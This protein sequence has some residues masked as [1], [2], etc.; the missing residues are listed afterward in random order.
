VLRWSAWTGLTVMALVLLLALS[1]VID[2]IFGSGRLAALV[3]VSIPQA[4]GPA[5]GAFVARPGGDRGSVGRGGQRRPAVI[6]LHEFWGLTPEI[7]SK[8]TL[9]SESEGYVVVAPDTLRGTTTRWFPRALYQAITTPVERVN[10]DL[11]VVFAWLAAQPDVDPARIAVVGFC[12]GGG[13]AFA[14]SLHSTRLAATA[15]FYG[16][17]ET[18]PARLRE[19]RA[20]VLGIFGTA[21]AQIPVARV[22]AF[23]AGLAQAG[24]PSQV[25]LYEGQPHAFVKD[26]GS[27]RSDPVQAQAWAELTAFLRTHLKG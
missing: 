27:I 14:Y 23:E 26:A 9:L 4:D 11:D 18:D 16:S 25:T 19:L 8:A 1:I 6:M 12:Y 13:K 17:V 15:V 2:P 21:D 22:Q 24:I 5:I 7:N 3:N 10:G 20:P